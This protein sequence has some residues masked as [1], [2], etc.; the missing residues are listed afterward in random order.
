MKLH[1]LLYFTLVF[2]ALSCQDPSFSIKGEVEGGDGRSLILEKADNAGIWTALD[3]TRLKSNGKFSF[4]MH[5]PAAPEIYRLAM[6]GQYIYFPIDS[7]ENLTLKT[8]VAHFSNGFDIEGSENAVN[9]AAFEKQ[10]IEIMPYL[11]TPDSATDFKRRVYSEYLQHARGSVVS[12]YILTKTVDGK[13]LFDIADDSGYFAA[14]ATGFRQFRPSDPRCQLLEETA[15]RGMRMKAEA[16]GKRRGMTAEEISFFPISLPDEKGNVVSLNEV[17][18]KGTPT[19]LLFSD[20]SDPATRE[21]NAELK[22][23]VEQGRI[24]VYNV[25]LDSDHLVWKNAAVNLPFTTVHANVSAATEVCSSYQV[26]ALPTFFIINPAGELTSRHS[27][28]R[29]VLKAL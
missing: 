9:M 10:L 16:S 1:N 4:S 14:V 6:D 12:Y 26:A 17:A 18:G 5:A 3:S 27:D 23:L 11:S 2:G 8:S 20:L 21:I 22:R 7:T 15:T 25:G 28:I 13:P 19:V 24:K 29:E